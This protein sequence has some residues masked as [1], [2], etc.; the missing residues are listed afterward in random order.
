V[1]REL[2]PHDIC[3]IL[4]F[5]AHD[6]RAGDILVDEYLNELDDVWGVDTRN[7]I[8]A[9]EDDPLDVYRTILE[10]SDA[11]EPV[12]RGDGGELSVLSPVGS[13][14][15]AL[16]T[17]MAAI[18]R[19]FTVLHVE[20]VGFSANLSSLDTYPVE[21]GGFA[22]VWLTGEPYPPGDGSPRESV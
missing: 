13:K 2:A 17:L 20:A 12:F 7:L 3:P 8:H 15:L 10:L 19:N 18:E 1:F 6:P 22:H 4:P 14:V 11:R 21:Q 16:G 9:A 5:P